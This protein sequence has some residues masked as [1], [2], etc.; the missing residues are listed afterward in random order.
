MDP[1]SDMLNR[2]K[3]AQKVGKE[4]IWVP[5]SKMCYEV[6]KVMRKEG[7]LEAVL[8]KGKPPKRK[9]K[10]FLKYNNGIPAI[11]GIRKISKPSL[12][13]YR[14]AKDISSPRQGF[15]IFII[16]S[17]KGLVTDKEARHLH[18]GGEIICEIW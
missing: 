11:S 17:P 10:I 9:I 3:T 2:I 4:F 13:I 7:F 6:A 16:S 14:K 18:V 1:I 5:F 8:K 12:R 15:G